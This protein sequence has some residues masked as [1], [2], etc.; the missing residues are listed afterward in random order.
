MCDPVTIS[1][2]TV[3]AGT[4]MSAGGQIMGAIGQEEAA[5]RSADAAQ[6]TAN[7][8]ASSYDKKVQSILLQAKQ[9]GVESSRQQTALQRQF[10]EMEGTIQTVAAMGGVSGQSVTKMK[11]ASAYQVGEAK[12]IL[13]ENLNNT[14]KQLRLQV[15]AERASAM[16]SINQAQSNVMAP[17]S[18]LGTAL[19]VG[20]TLLE[21]GYSINQILKK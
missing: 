8:I 20:S 12:S 13:G 1:V 16:S 14:L 2:A 3:A 21:G 11:Q 4:A 17:P 7:S 15:E 18:A 6:S 5:S 9:V 10:E 19:S